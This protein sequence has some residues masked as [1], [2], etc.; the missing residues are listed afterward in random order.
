MLLVVFGLILIG[1]GVAIGWYGLR[2]LTVLPRL[3]QTDPVSP[4]EVTATDSFVVC[5][6]T[7]TTSGK[8]VASPF[9]GTRC[10]G[11]EFEVTER[12]PFAIGIPWFQAHVDDG[13]ATIPFS[14][15]DQAGSIGVDPSPRRFSLDIEPR[16]VAVGGSETPPSRIQRF[17]DSRDGVSAPA[18]WLTLIPG[19]GYR[20]YVERRIDPDEK[21][22][23]A[24]RPEQQ[25]GTTLLTGNLVIADHSPNRIVL[26]R[27][28]A[29]V[30]PVL[31]AIVFVAAGASILTL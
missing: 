29:S 15:E 13:V 17:L 11:F 23:V 31:I 24:G 10:L 22:V 3:L 26:N 14:L 19:L 5:R 30:F 6:G 18:S 4:A 12:Q 25:G 1:L 9:T 16:T 8:T 21:Y 2:P 28:L 27:L 20:R 7:A